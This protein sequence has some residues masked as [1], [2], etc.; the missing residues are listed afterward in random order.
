MLRSRAFWAWVACALAWSVSEAGAE[1]NP[2]LPQVLEFR[3]T[4]TGRAQIAI[5]VENEAGEFMA[6][7]AL[8]DAVATRGLGNRPGA[9]QMNSGFRWPYGR[10]EGVLPIWAHSRASA[11]DAKL[12]RRVIFQ[13]RPEGWASRK[14]EDSSPDNYFCLAWDQTRSKQEALDA[15]SCASVFS[16]DKGRF[17]TD[18]DA[19][20]GY[21]EPYENVDST[22]AGRLQ[23]MPTDSLYPPRR[24]ITPCGAG[25]AEHADAAKFAQHARE[26]MPDIDAVSVATLAADKAARSLF[27][28]PEGWAPGMYRACLE[29]N[30]EGDYNNRF[31]AKQ[32]PTPKTPPMLWDS[33]A[34]TQGYGYA[35]RG[36]PSIAYCVPFEL[37]LDELME[38]SSDAAEGGAG[39]WDTAKDGYGALSGMEGMTDDP[40]GAPGSGADRLRKDSNGHRLRVIVKPPMSCEGNAPPGSV[41]Q[42]DVEPYPNELHAHEWVGMDFMA[43]SD[44]TAIFRYEVRVS[45]DPIDDED[46][47]MRGQPAKNA[48]IEAEELDVPPTTRAGTMVHVDM[49]GLVQGTHYYV[50][51]RAVDGCAA[52]GDIKVAEFTTPMRVFATVTPCFVATAA[53]GSPMAAEIGVLRRF[54]DR[55]LA[56]H[57][58]GRQ[59]VAAYYVVGPMLADQ[60]RDHDILRAGAR[61]LLTPLVAVAHWLD[62]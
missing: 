25:C 56:T 58:I 47:F 16:S 50:G 17:M 2:A 48:T 53:Y 34:T 19:A 18:A 15:V 39:S 9:S 8:T 33:W 1:E 32:L 37:G 12:W 36:Q 4:P 60:I 45:T 10:R 49:G 35:Y 5:W 14:R 20:A 28:V 22:H 55:Q 26:V 62:H 13:D 23:A 21:G 30:V 52:A 44:D 3:Y 7:V 54:R 51:I 42:L 6:T 27:M 43:A 57:W 59:L 46:S 24:D 11:P 61:A 40:V 31:D 38:Y 29:I 41:D